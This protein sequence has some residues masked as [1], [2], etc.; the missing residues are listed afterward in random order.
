MDGFRLLYL[1]S[2]T[3][4]EAHHT[5][6][7]TYTYIKQSIFTDVTG[8]RF[9]R[10]LP[11]S[12]NEQRNCARNW[13]TPNKNEHRDRI[14]PLFLQL[15]RSEECIGHRLHRRRRLGHVLADEL[16]NPPP[17]DTSSGVISIFFFLSST[18]FFYLYSFPFPI[19]SNLTLPFCG[20][21]FWHIARI[22][23]IYSS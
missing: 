8:W 5:P 4:R 12:Q 11:D 15:V 20:L 22:S 13:T 7:Y 14:G 16:A 2:G 1:C 23:I 9:F 18:E 21:I 3:A 6:R 17:H 10:R 19:C